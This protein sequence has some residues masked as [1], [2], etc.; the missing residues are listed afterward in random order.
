MAAIRILF[1]LIT[2]TRVAFSLEPVPQSTLDEAQAR[3]ADV[4]LGMTRGEVEKI[5]GE[6][7]KLYYGANWGRNRTA[8][9]KDDNMPGYEVKIGFQ[10]VG[11][12]DLRGISIDDT[13][14]ELPK[15]ERK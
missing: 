13:V 4:K 12:G 6:D 8:F 11:H 15:L 5:L 7:W 14:T 1:V 3:I 2:M 10:Y 9:Y